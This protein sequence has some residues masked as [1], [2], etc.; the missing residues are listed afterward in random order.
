MNAT[1]TSLVTIFIACLAGLVSAA[2]IPE[3]M[4]DPSDRATFQWLLE[5]AGAEPEV[6]HK[7][8]Q[9]EWIGFK[10]ESKYTCGLFLD[11]VTVHGPVLGN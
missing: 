11:E 8:E 5:R 6:H 2:E 3:E 7:R 9:V 10:G 1:A 4:T